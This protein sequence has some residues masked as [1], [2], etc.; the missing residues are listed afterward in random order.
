MDF[1]AWTKLL[2]KTQDD[3][4]VKAALAAAGVKKIPKLDD[5]ETFVQ[6]ELKG[7][8]LEL[9][10]TDE[11][12]LKELEDQ[13]LGEGPLIVSGVVAK[14]DKA[15]GRDLYKGPLPH[16]IAATMSQA[17]LRKRLG[18]PSDSDVDA[19]TWIQD[20]LELGVSYT[21]GNGSLY[22]LSLTLPNAY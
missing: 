11:A 14:L 8:G 15:Q 18:K 4:D 19:D 2:G 17:E 20:G 1:E 12:I 5:D 13:D 21:K 3:A 7:Q 6:V 9:V 16:G 10:L 22:G